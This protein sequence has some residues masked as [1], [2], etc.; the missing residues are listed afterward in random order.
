MEP[1]DLRALR[2]APIEVYESGGAASAEFAAGGGEAHVHCV[3]FEPGGRI[4]EHEA[5]FG[6]LFLVLEGRGWIAGADGRRIEVSVGQGAL[7]ARGEIHAKGS[8][9]G[10]TALMLQVRELLPRSE[11]LEPTPR[12]GI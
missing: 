2:C 11:A 3:R 12:R 4:G 8:D 6:Q 5:G 9:S 7:L 1:I 10:M